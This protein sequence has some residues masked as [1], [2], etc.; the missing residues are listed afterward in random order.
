[1]G[2]VLDLCRL[3]LGT[4][5]LLL[6]GSDQTLGDLVS[7]KCDVGAALSRRNRIRERNLLELERSF[8]DGKSDLP[9]QTNLLVDRGQF[10]LRNTPETVVTSAAA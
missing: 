2:V 5:V 9:A 8:R 7:H 3:D 6:D 4:L 1:M 10:R